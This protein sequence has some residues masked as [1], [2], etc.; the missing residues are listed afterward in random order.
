MSDIEIRQLILDTIRE[1]KEMAVKLQ[2]TN[3]IQNIVLAFFFAFL[4]FLTYELMA[5]KSNEQS[6]ITINQ[7]IK[8]DNKLNNKQS[9]NNASVGT[10]DKKADN[11]KSLLSL[12]K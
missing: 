4:L 11:R 5:M 1:V 8:T 3:N 12:T 9:T 7:E 2:R 10:I 6:A